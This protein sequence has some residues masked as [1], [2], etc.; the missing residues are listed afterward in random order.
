MDVEIPDE[1]VQAVKQQVPQLDDFDARRAT[2]AA[3]PLIRGDI[4]RKAAD[5][6]DNTVPPD[7]FPWNS[8]SVD[9]Q[10][11]RMRR[12]DA[13]ILRRLATEEATGGR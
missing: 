12:A 3:L 8:E 13:D 11:A 9:G 5:Y 10:S 2:V 4:L 6:L 1:A 7:V